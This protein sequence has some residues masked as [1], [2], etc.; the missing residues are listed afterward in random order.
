MNAHADGDQYR[1]PAS[2]AGRLRT[3]ASAA[4][5]ALSQS[6]LS[7]VDVQ[8]PGQ[9]QPPQVLRPDAPPTAQH[10]Q[11]RQGRI[12][13]ILAGGRPDQT[14]QRQQG[15]VHE[16]GVDQV[17][18]LVAAGQGQHLVGGQVHRV[19]L[20]AEDLAAHD[21]HEPPGRVLR[22][23]DLRRLGAPPHHRPDVARLADLHV[24]GATGIHQQSLVRGE[25]RGHTLGAV[26]EVVEMAAVAAAVGL[27]ED[28]GP[29]CQVAVL[30]AVGCQ[31][32]PQ[33]GL[34]SGQR[35]RLAPFSHARR[36]PCFINCSA[37]QATSSGPMARSG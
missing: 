17:P 2:A 28:G 12:A 23:L 13:R 34:E 3:N 33:F 16:Q 8:V 19:Q 27:G 10:L 21:G 7:C 31:Q 29:A 32:P 30:A 11:Q 36:S 26:V 4:C 14:A 5:C 20:V 24:H 37:T 15:V 25:G 35:H 18:R 22:P 6:A 1:H 9:I